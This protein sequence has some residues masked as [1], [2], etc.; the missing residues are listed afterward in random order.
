MSVRPCGDMQRLIDSDNHGLYQ[1]CP[2]TRRRSALP[3]ARAGAEARREGDPGAGGGA[4]A[5]SDGDDVSGAGGV[6]Q[7][8][9][10][11]PG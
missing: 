3:R 10:P 9:G 1:S 4:Q 6:R 11:L 7:A 8:A 2:Q 5:G